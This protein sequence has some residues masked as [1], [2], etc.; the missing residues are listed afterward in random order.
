MLCSAWV[1]CCALLFIS[2]AFHFYRVVLLPFPF[3]PFFPSFFSS[4]LVIFLF[5][6]FAANSLICLLAFLFFEHVLTAVGIVLFILHHSTN[7]SM[8]LP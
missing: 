5:F 8:K 3:Q 7:S 6:C 2:I 4:L 1:L